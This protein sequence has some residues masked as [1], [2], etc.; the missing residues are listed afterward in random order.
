[1]MT[2]DAQQQASKTNSSVDKATIKATASKEGKQGRKKGGARRA[3]GM[4]EVSRQGGV[5]YHNCVAI[6]KYMKMKASKPK[7][8]VPATQAQRA[9]AANKISEQ[10]RACV[11]RRTEAPGKQETHRSPPCSNAACRARS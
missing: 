7:L 10:W 6:A 5:L 2:G 11:P 4:K 8:Q 9:Q 3:R 1:M